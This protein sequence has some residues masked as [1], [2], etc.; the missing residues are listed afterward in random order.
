MHSQ[1]KCAHVG[2]WSRL[3]TFKT[4]QVSFTKHMLYGLCVVLLGGRKPNPQFLPSHWMNSNETFRFWSAH[5]AILNILLYF[6]YQIY[7]WN[8]SW[9]SIDCH[10]GKHWLIFEGRHWLKYQLH[11]GIMHWSTEIIVYV[12]TDTYHN[13]N[14]FFYNRIQVFW[15]FY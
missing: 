7:I 11:N 9:Q 14:I 4:Y 2:I 1:N 15:E 10:I 13:S 3:S 6:F 12:E 8:F 5:N